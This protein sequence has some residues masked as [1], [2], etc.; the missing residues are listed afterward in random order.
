[1]TPIRSL[2]TLLQQA[3][4]ERDVALATLQRAQAAA[5][6]AHQQADQLLSYRRDYERRW[7]GQFA[8]QGTMDIV[9]CYQSFMQRLSQAVEQQQRSAQYSARQA[10]AA[11]DVLRSHEMRVA[12]IRKLIERRT[13]ETQAALAR[14]EQRQNDERAAQSARQRESVGV[15]STGTH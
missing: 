12:S 4:A 14:S 1:M 10:Q 15:A 5:D 9:Q 3:Q 13:R 11:G 7:N 2:M 8:Q 6:R